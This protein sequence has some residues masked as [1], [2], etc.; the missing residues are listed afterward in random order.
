M[1]NKFHP[2]LKPLTLGQKICAAFLGQHNHVL[3]FSDE[4]QEVNLKIK[5]CILFSTIYPKFMT[6]GGGNHEFHSKE[7]KNA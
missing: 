2:T 5:H 4:C 3:S 7:A 6:A 1:I